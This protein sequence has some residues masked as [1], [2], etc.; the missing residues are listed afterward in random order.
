MA[1][2]GI[3]P[4]GCLVSGK[5]VKKLKIKHYFISENSIFDA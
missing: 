4:E 3:R 2:L 5:R 1:F